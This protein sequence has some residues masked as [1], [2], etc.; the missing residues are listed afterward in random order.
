MNVLEELQA[1][2]HCEMLFVESGGDNLAG[3]PARP[4]ALDSLSDLI[5]CS[6]LLE[7]AG[8][9]HHLRCQLPDLA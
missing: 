5:I 2:Y 4:L 9:L 8:R 1:E 3:K 7:R 6:K